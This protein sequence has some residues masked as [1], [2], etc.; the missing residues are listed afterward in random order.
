MYVSGW[1][2]ASGAL[3]AQRRR[4]LGKHGEV[5]VL[6]HR[7]REALIRRSFADLEHER[8]FLR[9]VEEDDLS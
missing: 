2:G 1:G 3:D 4:E 9:V 8:E 5:L 7:R 6:G